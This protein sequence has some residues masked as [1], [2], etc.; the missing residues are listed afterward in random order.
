MLSNGMKTEYIHFLFNL[1]VLAGPT[2][3]SRITLSRL[4]TWMGNIK[5]VNINCFYI[6]FFCFHAVYFYE[7]KTNG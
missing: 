4:Q 7:I 1:C 3:P 5:R 2:V 6:Q